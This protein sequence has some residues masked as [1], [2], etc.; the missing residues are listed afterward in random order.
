LTLLVAS[1]QRRGAEVFCELL[2]AALQTH[3][4]RTELVALSQLGG[5]SIGA[6]ALTKGRLGKLH[7][8]TLWRLWRHLRKRKPDV[9]LAFGSSTLKYAVGATP[10]G[11]SAKVVYASI[12]EPLYWA[13]TPRQRLTYKILLRRVD[14]VLSV[15]KRTSS[16]LSQALGVPRD[17]LRVTPTGVPSSYLDI[18]PA[19]NGDDFRVLFIGSLS[20]EKDPISAIDAFA[21]IPLIHNPRLRMLGAGPLEET[22]KKRVGE[23]GLEGRVEMLGSVARIEP[24]LAWAHA[25]IL[26]SQTEGLPAVVLEAASAGVPAVAYDV[27]GV[28]EAVVNGVT[29]KLVNSGDLEGISNA[30]TFYASHPGEAREAGENARRAVAS[31]F[32]IEA[33]AL[34]FDEALGGLLE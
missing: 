20:R 8:P 12:G 33:S 10:F 29:G 17:K 1:T 15:S 28:S 5:P 25:L 34:G 9:L 23:L 31:R 13:R 21:R 26:T 7:L 30:L 16:Q 4:W 24:H 6:L 11:V 2:A 22:L 19:R 27:G 18:A 32:T 14:L 3:R